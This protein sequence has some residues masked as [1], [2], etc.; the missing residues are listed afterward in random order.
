MLQLHFAPEAT[1]NP[2]CLH[3]T[4]TQ[5]FGAIKSNQISLR[6]LAIQYAFG[7]PFASKFS[8]LEDLK[9]NIAINNNVRPSISKKATRSGEL[10]KA[11]LKSELGKPSTNRVAAVKKVEAVDE[12][13]HRQKRLHARN[14]DN[15]RPVHARSVHRG[16][17]KHRRVTRR[18]PHEYLKAESTGD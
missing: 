9:P 11:W 13:A 5:H 12:Q 6:D 18:R 8:C 15:A 4:S 7:M 14:Q 10:Q 16:Y 3:G 17:R 1:L 2:R